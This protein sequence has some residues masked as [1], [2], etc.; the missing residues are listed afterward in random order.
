MSLR[1]ETDDPSRAFQEPPRAATARFAHLAGAFRLPSAHSPGWIV[2]ESV[3]AAAFSLISM[4]AIG[5]LIGP[6]AAGVGT[7]AITAFLVAD[8]LLCALFPDSLVRPT[9]LERRHID[10]AATV[11]VLLG[12][13]AGAG[14][15]LLGPFLAAASG[16][17]QVAGL[18]L[19]LAPLLPLSALSGTACGLYLRAE[20]YRLLA[21]RLLLGQPLA[22]SAGLALSWWGYGAWAMVIAQAVST[23]VTFILVLRGGFRLRPGLDVGALR[24]LWPVAWPQLAGA[25]VLMGKYRILLMAV[26][27]I[28]SPEV[29]AVLHFAFRLVDTALGVVGQIVS[30]IALPRLC[31]VRRSRTALADTYGDM[32]QLQALIGLPICIGSTLLAPDFVV[33]LLGPSWS[34]MAVATQI[35]AAGATASFLYGDTNSLFVATGKARWNAGIALLTLALPLLLLAALR[36]QTP[37][38]IALLWASQ[39]L[40]LPPVMTVLAL[41]ELHR[42]LPWLARRAV[43]GAVAALV[44]AAA[45]LTVQGSLEPGSWGRLVGSAAA[46]GIAFLLVAWIGLGG[47]VPRAL[48]TGTPPCP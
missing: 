29:L 1:G 27:L 46:G 41:R 43:L 17:P 40:A 24:E 31:A 6:H 36:P 4:L 13:L 32:A 34:G 42:P 23:T 14:L 12:L 37:E 47:R 25:A 21:A 7:L 19:C 45:I 48:A 20:R 22:L 38:D 44:M 30:R 10:S 5:R 15:A 39:S 9:R 35:V 18:A 16:E 8:G 28:A 33:L 2:A 11:S 26:S 3:A